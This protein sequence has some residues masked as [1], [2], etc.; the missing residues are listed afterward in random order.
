LHPELLPKKFQKKEQQEWEN[1]GFIGFEG[2]EIELWK[3]YIR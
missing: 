1:V 2:M 3:E